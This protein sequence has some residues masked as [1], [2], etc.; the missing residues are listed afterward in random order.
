[1]ED[2]NATPPQP[3]QGHE[4]SRSSGSNFQSFL[5]PGAILIAAVL[6]SGT[7]FYTRANPSGQAAQIGNEE[8][9][10]P[11][12][13]AITDQDHILGNKDAKVTIVEFSDFQCPFCRSFFEAAHQ[14]IK[15]EYL[16]TGKARLI[17]RHFP[18]GFHAGAKPA[19]MG[20]ECAADQGKFWEFHDKIFQEQAKSGQGTV[21][22]T[23]T[24]IKRWAANLKLNT[25]QFNEC[26]DSSKYSKRVDDDTAYGASINVSGTPSFFVNGKRLVGAQPFAAFKAIID[27]ALTE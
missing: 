20:S 10:K 5:M 26:L 15:K 7:L 3:T 19:A 21:Q 8:D 2:I 22:F 6:I 27:E 18:L 1:M 13:I 14:Q 9:T 24:D 12:D 16:D 17:F 11:V 4:P 23:T 25:K